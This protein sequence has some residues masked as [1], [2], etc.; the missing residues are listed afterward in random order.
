[1]MRPALVIAVDLN[2]RE[3][4]QDLRA[5]GYQLSELAKASATTTDERRELLVLARGLE[6]LADQA[7]A[8]RGGR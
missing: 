6:H 3:A 4:E 2:L 8:L 1:M 5:R 7:L